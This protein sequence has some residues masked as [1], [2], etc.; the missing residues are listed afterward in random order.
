MRQ[1]TPSLP[2][3]LFFYFDLGCA[4]VA[5][6]L[7]YLLP[8]LGAWPLLIGLLPW[9]IRLIWRRR[10]SHRTPYDLPLLIFL[11]TGAASVWAAYGPVE[12][13]AK[14][15]LIV[16]AILIFYAF[17]N[18]L[19]D[20]PGASTHLPW[21]LAL[22]GGVVS[23]YFLL[24][25]DW[26]QMPAK[27]AQLTWLGVAI[28]SPLPY[29]PG[30]RLNPNVVGGILAMLLPFAGLVFWEA[31]RQRRWL[32]TLVAGSLLAFTLFAM[33]LS[34]S[35]GG[36]LALAGAVGLLGWWW[37]TGVLTR[38][39]PLRRRSLFFGALGVALLSILPLL[40]LLSPDAP[41]MQWLTTLV[42]GDERIK[43]FR[44][45][46]I[47]AMDY[48]FIGAGLEGFM[49]LYSTYA[50]L[51]HVGYIVHAHNLF[52]DIAIEQGSVALAS[53]LWMWLIM[54]LAI[55][56]E[57]KQGAL[58]PLTVAAA[59]SVST[60]AIHGLLDDALYGS[61]ALLLLFIPLALL[62]PMPERKV[63]PAI[64]WTRLVAAVVF[65]LLVLLGWRPLLSIYH[66]NLAN[67]TQSRLEL[68][69]YNWPEWPLQDAV[70]QEIDLEPVIARYQQALDY[71]PDNPSAHRRLGQI[72]LS[73]GQYEAALEHLAAAY[74][75]T[76]WDNATRQLY[77]EALIV[78]GQVEE[79]AA[80]WRTVHTKQNQLRAREYWYDFI[81][82]NGR[83]ALIRAALP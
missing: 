48:P 60:I 67:V 38:Q 71:W 54:G 3:W 42:G 10:P 8:E 55:W 14:F 65:L 72:Q 58:R 74:E 22:F 79:G 40:F 70:R 35:R 4:L 2:K 50:F 36:W 44:N 5:G 27:Y 15:W 13:Q 49:M 26:E 78:N 61:R 19:L 30:H 17:A 7:W 18:S 47:L 82:D 37:L 64:R 57:A 76:P 80:L 12:A 20:F 46:L 34:T 73:L 39:R 1:I 41:L 28:Q 33:L 68:S 75:A 9:L 21:L 63:K 53:L 83:L 24:T 32:R 66:S 43:L 62:F 52:L 56:R 51:L 29:I 81:G 23:L 77:G 69:Q 25:H 31:M 16:G 59:L 11:A 45:S 6:G